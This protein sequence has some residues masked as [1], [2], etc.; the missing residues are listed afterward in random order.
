M[1]KTI[2]RRKIRG[3]FHLLSIGDV[4]ALASGMTLD[5]HHTFSGT[6]ALGGT[7]T[8]RD[9]VTAWLHRLFTILP[10]L[11]FDITA[12]AVGGWPWDTTVSVE[13]INFG[14]V[15]DGTHYRNGGS[16]IFRLRWGKVASFHA[17]LNDIDEI[18]EVMTRLA[19]L[20]IPEA[21][22]PPI[23]SGRGRA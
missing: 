9:D 11:K 2:V 7:R 18:G 13:W 14:V 19:A 17:Y 23:Q 4:D 5:V 15:P 6:H 16:H 3:A 21:A 8:N 10:G 20:G 12:M 22:L 1:Y